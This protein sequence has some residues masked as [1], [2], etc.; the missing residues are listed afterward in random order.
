MC[1]VVGAVAVGVSKGSTSGVV[2]TVHDVHALA[3]LPRKVHRTAKYV[4]APSQDTLPVRRDYRILEPFSRTAREPSYTKSMLVRTLS[5][6]L[7]IPMRLPTSVKTAFA[8]QAIAH[9]AWKLPRERS[10]SRTRRAIPPMQRMAKVKAGM[11]GVKG[12]GVSRAGRTVRAEGHNQKYPNSN[13]SIDARHPCRIV[14]LRQR[15]VPNTRNT[16]AT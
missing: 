1:T 10:R 4:I 11:L 12:G 13:P 5:V 3:R 16:K 6:P 15:S 9:A 7:P 8:R 2:A 14:P